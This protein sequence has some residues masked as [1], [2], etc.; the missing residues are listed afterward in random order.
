MKNFFKKL[1]STICAVSVSVLLL[2]ASVTAF[3]SADAPRSLDE[4]GTS[5]TDTMNTSSGTSGSVSAGSNTNTGGVS[6][7]N[8]VTQS[9]GK[10]TSS[11]G[12]GW[13]GFFWFI[14]S[15][16]VNFII[17]CWVGNRFY[18][19]ARRSAQGSAE[20][21]ALR[22]DIEEKFAGTITDISEPATE[23]INR[24]ENY[25]RNDDGI[26]MPERKSHVELN[27]DELEMMRRWDARRS[28][29]KPARAAEREDDF[30]E[31]ENEPASSRRPVRSAYQPTRRSSGIEF[32]DEDGYDEDEDPRG[33]RRPSRMP[34]KKEKST[35]SGAISNAK[36]KAKDFLSNVFPFDE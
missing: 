8:N 6:T 27:S 5:V 30:E 20:I 1:I 26:T 28:A 19:M 29:A 23:V 15:V 31:E 34:E 14:L 32:E 36:N 2:T 18:R 22:K 35:A 4:A 12:S 25:A 33:A 17:S 3:A 21:R 24:N 10:K 9:A 7:A 13:S 16:I 11:K